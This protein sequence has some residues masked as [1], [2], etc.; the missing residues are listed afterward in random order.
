MEAREDWQKQQLS[1]GFPFGNSY[2]LS[3]KVNC[4]FDQ[5]IPIG[6]VKPHPR[7]RNRHP[8]DQI[9]RLAK[10][11]KYQ[12]WRYPVKISKLSGYVT[13]GHGRIEAAK[14][15]GWTEVPVNF[16]EY[17]NEDQEYADIIA[18]NS[19]AEWSELSLA[20]INLDIGDLDPGFDI[21]MLGFKDFHVEPADKY[22]DQDADA[23][24]EN[25]E[26]KT[27]LGD[28]YLLGDHRLLCGDSTDILQVERLMNG[29]K[30]DLVSMDPPY[31][32]GSDS[33][34][35]AADVSKS[36][37]DLKNSEWDKNFSIEPALD[38]LIPVVSDSVTI[39]V[40][41]SQFLIQKIWDHLNAWCDFTSYCVWSK[42]NPMP[43]LTKRHWTWSTELC[44]YG[45]RGSKRK[46]N[47][48]ED[49]HASN[50]WQFVKKSDGTH[51]TQK[52]ISLLEHHI[53]FSSD[54]GQKVLDLFGGSG[55]TLIAC[56][57]TNRKCF[58]MELDPHYCDVIVARWEK[59]TG[60]TAV[61]S[62]SV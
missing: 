12:G 39:Y 49:G 42:P 6:D 44:V 5:M 21:E 3:M 1:L 61:L 35:Y 60:K 18:D 56:E 14:L 36:M 23:I 54:P 22:A 2:R 50:V 62:S 8:E 26:P 16:Q 53:K 20:D 57:K 25:V 43:S 30:A 59:F 40:W 13:S 7:N 27:K 4:L 37:E 15:N 9:E 48:P 46:V 24:P 55:S 33:K 52:P 41:T 19:I 17:E 51:P 31:N 29:E 28:L 47:F 34:N 45:T 38:C 11:L 32:I 10:I 58:M